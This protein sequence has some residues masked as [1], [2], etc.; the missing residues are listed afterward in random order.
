MQTKLIYG[1]VE[2]ATLE[3]LLEAS[4]MTGR[5]VDELVGEAVSEFVEEQRGSQAQP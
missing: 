3:S 2:D 4:E 1:P 5:S